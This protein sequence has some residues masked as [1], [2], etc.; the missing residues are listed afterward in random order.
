MAQL[1][2][3]D[4]N[5]T[6]FILDPYPTFAAMHNADESVFWHE[7]SGLWFVVKHADLNALMKD[8]RLGRQITHIMSPAELGWPPRNPD[9]AAFY[10]LGDH[11]LFDKEPPDHTRIKSLVHKVFTP[12]R[13]ESLRGQIETITHDLLD[14]V[15]DQGTMDLLEDYAVP[16]P[17]M[18]IAELLGIPAAM[19]PKL[20]PWSADIVKMYELNPSPQSAQEAV[21]AAQEFSDFL[22]ELARERRQHPSDDLISALALV[23]DG[24]AT[25]TEDELV[26]TCILLLNA[27]HEATVN[28]FGNGMLA[29]LKNPDQLARLQNDLSR[30]DSAVEEMLRYDSPSQLFRRWVLEDM[31]YKGHQFKLGQEVA[32]L[33]GAANR[34]PSVF[35]QP[36]Q[37]DITRNPNPHITFGVGIHYC[38]GAPLGRLEMQISLRTLLERCPN[39]QLATE[40]QFKESFVLRGLEA[41][42]VKF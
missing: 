22:R 9:Y 25:L 21:Q 31:D 10:A 17:V 6:D 19:R 8:R 7:A 2:P 26:S 38:L 32:F 3:F 34:D 28:G 18:V 36:D 29:L 5:A 24:G 37:F 41:L 20:R 4:P 35:A 23:E 12:R 13:V 39:I 15:I 1:K 42:P 27:G 14:A 16:L 30:I 40:P 33:F 11:S